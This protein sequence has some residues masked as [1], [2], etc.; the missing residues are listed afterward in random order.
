MQETWVRP[1]SWED[2]LEEKVVTHSRILTW[3]I[4]W[5]EEPGGSPIMGSQKVGHDLETKQ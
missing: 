1:L 5:T 3:E 4:S 2:P